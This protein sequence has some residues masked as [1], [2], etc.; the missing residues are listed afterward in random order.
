MGKALIFICGIEKLD[1]KHYIRDII[2]SVDKQGEWHYHSCEST[3]GYA[4]ADICF[5][6]GLSDYIRGSR[7]M[8]RKQRNEVLTKVKYGRLKEIKSNPNLQGVEVGY[9]TYL[10]K[11]TH[12]YKQPVTIEENRVYYTLRLEF[13]M[14]E[15]ELNIFGSHLK[16]LP[17][18]QDG[19]QLPIDV[20]ASIGEQNKQAVIDT[21]EIYNLYE[22]VEKAGIVIDQHIAKPQPKLKG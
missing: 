20:L 5:I 8:G 7:K 16:R 11:D 12:L 15:G 10:R 19:T 13:Y 6:R 2:V 4:G 1:T 18:N 22:Q 14:M 3:Q 17:N 21:L 9:S